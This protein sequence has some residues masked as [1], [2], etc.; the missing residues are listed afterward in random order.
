MREGIALLFGCAKRDDVLFT[1]FC[2]GAEDGRG[3]I[4]L[5]DADAVS[6]TRSLDEDPRTADLIRSCDAL[7]LVGEGETYVAIARRS[8][9]PV[10]VLGEDVE[11]PREAVVRAIQLARGSFS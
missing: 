10:V 9:V 1:A 11:E 5:S 8:G 2:A 6:D 4:P 3:D 7:I